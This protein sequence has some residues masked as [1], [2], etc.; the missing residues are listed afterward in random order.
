TDDGNRLYRYSGT[1]WVDVADKTPIDAD[2][3]PISA[4]SRQVYIGEPGIA[5]ANGAMIFV[6]GTFTHDQLGRL[7]TAAVDR[8]LTT[9]PG[10][11]KS[12]SAPVEISAARGLEVYKGKLNVWAGTGG[13]GDKR[14]IHDGKVT[15]DGI[16]GMEAGKLQGV[17]PLAN[18]PSHLIR[19]APGLSGAVIY[20]G[21]VTVG[22]KSYVQVTF[23]TAMPHAPLVWLLEKDVPSGSAWWWSERGLDVKDIFG[24]HMPDRDLIALHRWPTTTGFRIYNKRDD[25]VTIIWWAFSVSGDPGSSSCPVCQTSCQ[26]GCQLEC[27]D[28]C[29]ITCQDTCQ[30]DCQ[31]TCEG[32]CQDACMFSCQLPPPLTLWE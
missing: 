28:S 18:L 2:E 13:A 17:V 10:G 15:N 19:S 3:R 26:T 29:Q 8:P 7:I 12:V 14:Y 11:Q 1:Q 27:E 16:L 24:Y 32:A 6:S 5:V 31:R 9:D 22:A 23:S 21:E 4:A 20:W 30:S 25:A